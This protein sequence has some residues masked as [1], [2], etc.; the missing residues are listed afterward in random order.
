M[1]PRKLMERLKGA[2]ALTEQDVG[3]FSHFKG[4]MMKISRPQL[5]RGGLGQPVPAGIPWHGG[6][7]AAGYAGHQLLR[8]GYPVLV[9]QYMGLF[10]AGCCRS[11]CWT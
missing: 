7:D 11:M 3:E 2:A 6:A 10:A 1:D 8:E 4:K 5:C 9:I